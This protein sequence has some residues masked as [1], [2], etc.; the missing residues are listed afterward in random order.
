MPRLAFVAVVFVLGSAALAQQL[1]EGPGRAETEKLC[2]QCHEVAR[3]IS[4]RLDRDGWGQTMTKMTAF[5]MKSTSEEYALVL[6]YLVK[7]YPA[8]DVPRINVNQATAIQLE[9]VLGLRRS[10]AKE[11][12]A[13]R[14]KN[15]DFKTID[16]LKKVP[17]LDAAKLDA[18]KDRILF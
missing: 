18:K 4:P 15:G 17:G 14:E 7:N 11:V 12:L 13:Y 2:K 16:D 9:S 5:G 3:S 8:E 10:Q 1:P 6:D